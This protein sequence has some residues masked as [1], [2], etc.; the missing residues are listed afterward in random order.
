[1][2]SSYGSNDLIK[3][4]HILK[5][6]EWPGNAAARVQRVHEPHLYLKDITFCTRRFLGSNYYT[7][8]TR[9]F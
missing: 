5:M 6:F 4:F 7:I 1:M 3:D 2:I 8:C 9:G